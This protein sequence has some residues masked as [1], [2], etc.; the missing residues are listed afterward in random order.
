MSHVGRNAFFLG[1]ILQK[2]NFPEDILGN[3]REGKRLTLRGF[4]THFK[5]SPRRENITNKVLCL[6]SQ[7]DPNPWNKDKKEDHTPKR[8]ALRKEERQRENKGGVH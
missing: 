4:I 2:R 6:C 3:R 8:L 7:L 5:W 1:S